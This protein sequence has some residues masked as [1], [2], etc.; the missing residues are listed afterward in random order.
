MKRI[1]NLSG[2]EDIQTRVGGHTL[3]H[4]VP[5]RW[6]S[7]FFSLLGEV[8]SFL[9]LGHVLLP[10]ISKTTTAFSPRRKAK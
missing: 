8:L 7:V 2:F 5:A 9:T 3:P 6:C 10:G 1:L 4:E